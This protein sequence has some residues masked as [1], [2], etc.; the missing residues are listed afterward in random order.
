MP[1]VPVYRSK[2]EIQQTGFPSIPTGKDPSIEA[3]RELGDTVSDLGS[4]LMVRQERR[5]RELDAIDVNRK[6]YGED[7]FFDQIGELTRSYTDLK[8]SDAYGITTKYAKEYSKL[9][10]EWL[11]SFP[12]EDQRKKAEDII[13]HYRK[14]KM[15]QISS[16][17][18]AEHQAAKK[19]A[20]STALVGSLKRVQENPKEV[21]AAIDLF[22]TT[23]AEVHTG[24]DNTK[25]LFDAEKKIRGAA[26]DATLEYAIAAVWKSAMP[27]PLEDGE[28]LIKKSGLPHNTLQKVLKDYRTEKKL[29]ND[30]FEKER[31]EQIEKND[32]QAWIEYHEGSLSW[33]DLSNRRSKRKISK[34]TFLSLEK[35]LRE[36][37]EEPEDNPIT[38]GDLSE[39][40]ASGIDVKKILKTALDQ[41]QITGKT[42][43]AM[44]KALG[45]KQ[46]GIATKI[47]NEALAPSQFDRWSPDKNLKHAQA[48]IDMLT[49]I[50][51]GKD[52]VD[53]AK[54]TIEDYTSHLRRTRNGIPKPTYLTGAKDD[55]GDLNEAEEVTARAYELKILSPDEYKRQAEI[56]N[57]L[58]G[59]IQDQARSAESNEKLKELQ[60]QIVR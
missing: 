21:D 1:K 55:L 41:K 8:E 50:A 32:D 17:E 15:A 54:E 10:Q 60:K 44:R 52:P 19:S 12:D 51:D 4:I 25:L 14:Q 27:L 16:H 34:S 47:L 2:R 39:S 13:L 57:D 42:Y 18:S 24:I 9:S 36:D 35:L 11:N 23:V 49:K 6:F 31:D 33:T 5:K 58:R 48:T 37:E 30:R 45:A 40:I 38:V 56:I 43:A 29:I 46:S 26:E 22:K 59:L 7:G 28:K 53:A 20:I 3:M